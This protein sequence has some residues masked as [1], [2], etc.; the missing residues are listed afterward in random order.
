MDHVA[1][2]PLLEIG[3]NTGISTANAK[4]E[5]RLSDCWHGAQQGIDKTSRLVNLRCGFGV[6]V[7]CATSGRGQKFSFLGGIRF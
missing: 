5:V 7:A 6:M 1:A 4:L 3:A 2:S